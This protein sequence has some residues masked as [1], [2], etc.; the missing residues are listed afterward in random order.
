[1]ER[2]TVAPAQAG[3]AWGHGAQSSQ[4]HFLNL[5]ICII[6]LCSGLGGPIWPAPPSPHLKTCW[7]RLRWGD[8]F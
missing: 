4:H 1:M 6:R 7:G 5:T 2:L 8:E 3:V